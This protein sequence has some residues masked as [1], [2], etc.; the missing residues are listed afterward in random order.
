MAAMAVSRNACG[1]TSNSPKR[2]EPSKMAKMLDATGA[3][4]SGCT[5]THQAPWCHT[6]WRR[7]R[8]YQC[9]ALHPFAAHDDLCFVSTYL[10]R[11]RFGVLLQVTQGFDAL[12]NQR[13]GIQRHAIGGLVVD[14]FPNG[15][16]QR[17]LLGGQGFALDAR[18][19]A[20]IFTRPLKAHASFVLNLL[21]QRLGEGFVALVGYDRQ[22]VHPLVLHTFTILVH[23]GADHARISWRFFMALL[24]SFSVQIWNTLGLSQPS[25]SAE[26]LK[27]NCKGTSALSRRSF[28]FHDELV[29]AV[30]L[31]TVPDVSTHTVLA[32][33]PLPFLSPENSRCVPRWHCAQ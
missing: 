4:G 24:V 3:P 26:W 11:P 10:G 8:R 5:R 19:G 18:L 33:T 22:H 23:T 6:P 14:L 13:W 12:R 27:M 32:F 16:K 30:V 31:A 20:G 17:F 15:L 29:G 2:P 25:R 7:C 1:L 9:A 21:L 28:V